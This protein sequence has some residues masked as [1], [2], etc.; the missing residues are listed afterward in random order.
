MIIVCLQHSGISYRM[1]KLRL[2]KLMGKK[3]KL[4]KENYLY[5]GWVRDSCLMVVMLCAE[6]KALLMWMIGPMTMMDG[7]SWSF[8]WSCCAATDTGESH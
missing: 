5:Q 3:N 8:S 4:K 2:K 6:R 7:V 1:I